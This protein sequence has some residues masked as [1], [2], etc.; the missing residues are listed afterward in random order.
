MKMDVCLSFLDLCFLRFLD[1]HILDR[2][3]F[4]SGAILRRNRETETYIPA[5]LQQAERNSQWTRTTKNDDVSKTA[6]DDVRMV[7]QQEYRFRKRPNGGSLLTV[8]LNS[9]SNAPDKPV[10]DP[11]C[12]SPLKIAKKL[13]DGN[14]LNARLIK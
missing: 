6:H 5:W 1:S 12:E 3:F 10:R 11:S 4:I 9:N 2:I 8:Q 14:N 7:F 13:S